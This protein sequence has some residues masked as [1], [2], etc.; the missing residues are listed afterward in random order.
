M[1]LYPF[2]LQDPIPGDDQSGKKPRFSDWQA[3]AVHA[4]NAQLEVWAASNWNIGLS[5][6]PSRL[7]VLDA[8][9]PEAEQWMERITPTPWVT[10]TAK[11]THSF[12]RLPD[13]LEPPPNKVRILACGLDRKSAGGYVVAPGSVHWT[14]VIY[15]ALG[16]WSTPMIEL[17][18]YDPR[19]FPEAKPLRQAP[20]AAPLNPST[21]V[22]KR[23]QGYLRGIPPAVSGQ[24]GNVHTYRVCCILTRDFALCK[25]DA[26]SALLDWNLTCSPPWTADE[27]EEI[28]DHAVSYASGQAGSKL[29]VAAPVK[30]G[31]LAWGRSL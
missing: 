26:F 28:L 31:G 9:T 29:A 14:G 2:P 27:L 7:V 17:P 15:E 24:G 6:G 11:G 20:M 3:L 19:W 13:S 25:M 4:T 23:A 22:M 18:A 21:D 30:A 5:L 16:D 10:R 8:D 1:G 12:Y